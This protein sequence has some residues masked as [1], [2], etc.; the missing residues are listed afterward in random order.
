MRDDD[1]YRPLK[2]VA[3]R[4]Y[5]LAMTGEH[6]DFA[7]IEEAIVDEGFAE[8]VPWLERPAVMGVLSEICVVSQS[9]AGKLERIWR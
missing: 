2:Y 8:F 6:S 5:E 3:R 4:A 9:R 7:S 1:D